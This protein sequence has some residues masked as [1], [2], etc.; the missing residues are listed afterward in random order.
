[1]RDLK[2]ILNTCVE[3]QASD[4]HITV[5]LPVT[6]RI[7]GQLVN[8]GDPPLTD[9]AIQAFVNEMTDAEQR[10]H[11]EKT[12]N[13]EFGLPFRDGIRF[14]VSIYRQRSHTASVL[15]RISSDIMS[16]DQI[17]LPP[18]IKT[19]LDK[20]NGMILVTG[21]TGSGKSTT[22][23]SMIDYVNQTD[24]RHIIT[25]EDPIEYVHQHKKSII[26]QREL[27]VDTVSFSK[28]LTEA[29]RQDPDVIL[30][31]EMRDLPT[32]ETAL[33]ATETGH[34][35]MSTVHTF[36]AART[37]DRVINVFPAHQQEQI[38][39]QLSLNLVAVISQ[40]LIPRMDG[41]GRVA[42]LEIMIMTPAIQNL[43]RKGQ[44][45]SVQNEIQTG[46]QF[47]MISLQNQ[48]VDLFKKG[49]ITKE[50]AFFYAIDQADIARRLNI[51]V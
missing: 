8:F 32:I 6:F 12:F 48:L 29:L 33:T 37:L 42:A 27:A 14:R 44:T 19:L 3:R 47:G 1:M 23:A 30:V 46:S 17:G 38:R 24:D 34:L 22:L 11:F 28:A 13:L 39:T 31:G 43:L 10:Q 18:V 25:V 20:N 9:D 4:I 26:N 15:R 35:V 45:F 40:Q 41:H 7:H 16:M 49:L 50:D 51:S 36:G 5:G 2:S 21:P